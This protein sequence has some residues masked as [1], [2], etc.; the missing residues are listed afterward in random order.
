MTT[1]NVTEDSPP[2]RWVLYRSR[3]KRWIAEHEQ[4][5]ACYINKR[6]ILEDPTRVMVFDSEQDAIAYAN[7]RNLFDRGAEVQL[8]PAWMFP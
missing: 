5:G 8:V 4:G 2:T 1:I 7:V 6:A 3:M